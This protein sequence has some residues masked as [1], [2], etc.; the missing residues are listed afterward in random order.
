MPEH[1]CTFQRTDTPT[2]MTMWP[3]FMQWN[4]NNGWTW[5]WGQ[6]NVAVQ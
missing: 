4:R 1:H 5:F 2:R 3:F 6:Q